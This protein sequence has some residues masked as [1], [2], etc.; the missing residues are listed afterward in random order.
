MAGAA[1]LRDGAMVTN[2]TP[3]MLIQWMVSRTRT[4][5]LGPS[6][7]ALLQSYYSETE[8]SIHFTSDIRVELALGR[9]LAQRVVDRA[10]NDGSQDTNR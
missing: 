9:T 1:V 5:R 7:M 3:N 6:V 4:G 8:D 2:A 10:K